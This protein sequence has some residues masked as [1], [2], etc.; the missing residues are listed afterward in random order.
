MVSWVTSTARHQPVSLNFRFDVSMTGVLGI[1]NDIRK[2][3]TAESEIA[4]N[5]VAL[6][7]KI[8]PLVQQGVLYKLISPFENNRC[9]LQYNSKDRN[10]SVIF[11]YNMADYL[12]GSQP[13]SR[14]STV[15][16]LKGLDQHKQYR[17]QRTGD[18][19]DKGSVYT[20]DFL[21][22][23]GIQWPLKNAFDSQVLTLNAEPGY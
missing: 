4:K 3:T 12:P 9:A 13:A 15:L 16:K 21:M 17:L 18:E 11:C 10:A 23:I 14:A 7:K 5:K 2:W 22:T 1:G 6:Y 19:K 8:R 20:G